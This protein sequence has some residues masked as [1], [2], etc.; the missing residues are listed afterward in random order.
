[1]QKL[2]KQLETKLGS[3]TNSIQVAEGGEAERNHGKDRQLSK[4]NKSHEAEMRKTDRE[5]GTPE[6]LKSQH[7]HP[8][9]SMHFS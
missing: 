3:L 4:Q 2:Q 7:S 5:R 8:N 9:Q 6:M 1:M